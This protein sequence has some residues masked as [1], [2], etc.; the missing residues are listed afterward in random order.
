MRVASLLLP[1]AGASGTRRRNRPTLLVLRFTF[2]CRYSKWRSSAPGAMVTV[3]VS[4]PAPKVTSWPRETRSWPGVTGWT[5]LRSRVAGMVSGAVSGP[6]R[7][8]V[9]VTEPASATWVAV[10]IRVTNGGSLSCTVTVAEADSPATT[11]EP[12]AVTSA[13]VTAP[14]SSSSSSSS[15]SR[16]SAGAGALVDRVTVRLPGAVAR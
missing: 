10:V 13:T 11:R 6:S 2:S 1:A 7:V 4:L 3:A 14:A 12:S 9:K 8:R 15:S 5:L 16:H